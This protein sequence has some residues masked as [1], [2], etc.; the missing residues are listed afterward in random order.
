MER[1]F[2]YFQK[3][4]DLTDKARSFLETNGKI[5]HF[6]KNNYYKFPLQTIE[7]W[8]FVI[9]GVVAF[10]TDTSMKETIERLYTTNSYFSGTKHAFSNTTLP[11]TIK[12]LRNTLIYE[13]S[14]SNFQHAVNQ[15]PDVKNIYLILKQQELIYYQQLILILRSPY[16]YRIKHLAE[17][18]PILYKEL[19]INEK[20][21]YLKIA[22]YNAYYKA[23]YYHLKN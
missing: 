23:L 14:N 1:M 20:M 4:H 13:I 6:K 7:K 10:I 9:L 21:F 3:Y 15:F 5:K 11:C 19:T 22:N 8:N 2:D 12:F 16:I 18:Q 17:L